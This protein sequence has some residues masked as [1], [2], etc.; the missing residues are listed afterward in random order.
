MSICNLAAVQ[1]MTV[2][3]EIHMPDRIPRNKSVPQG[4]EWSVTMN[5]L[6]TVFYYP[7]TCPKYFG[8]FPLTS[9]CLSAEQK[10]Q[11]VVISPGPEDVPTVMD[12]APLQA[13]P[14]IPV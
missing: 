13:L 12:K 4:E 10:L 14:A 8:N 7:L 3:K 1:L 9:A 11:F 2:K 5:G 6:A